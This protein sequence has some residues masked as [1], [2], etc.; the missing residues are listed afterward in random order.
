MVNRK[1]RSANFLQNGS[2]KK[3]ILD[4]NSKTKKVSKKVKKKRKIK[5]KVI[6]EGQEEYNQIIRNKKSNLFLNYSQKNEYY[7]KI[8]LIGQEYSELKKYS[9]SFH[10]I[11]NLL[12]KDT[13]DDTE[14]ISSSDW[15]LISEYIINKIRLVESNRKK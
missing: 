10:I 12:K 6:W 5:T 4:L 13:I 7:S 9:V 8:N 11:S 2:P 14:V 3:R 1:S 15:E